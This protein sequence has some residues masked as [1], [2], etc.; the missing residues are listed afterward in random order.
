MA[1][2]DDQDPGAWRG[3]GAEW[4]RGGAEAGRCGG[5]GRVVRFDKMNGNPDD[6]YALASALGDGGPA[7][8]AKIEHAGKI[9]FHMAGDT[10]CSTARKYQNE[11]HV[12]DHIVN[13]CQVEDAAERPAFL[14]NLGDLVYNFGEAAYYYDQ[15]YEPYRNYPAPI[16]AIPGNHDSFILPGTPDDEAPLEVFKRNFFAATLAP[17][18]DAG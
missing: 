2:L 5:E 8:V 1:R 12:C 11:L 13:D 9:V 3:S 6:V 18:Q 10:G 16:S 4:L 7:A 14:F 17:S 15:F